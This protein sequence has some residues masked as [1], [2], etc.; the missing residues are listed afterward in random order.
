MD[1]EETGHI[2]FKVFQDSGIQFFLGSGVVRPKSSM[3][4]G[5]VYANFWTILM[6]VKQLSSTHILMAY[7]T[8][9]W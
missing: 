1:L 4:S 9:L 8:H 2:P 3:I 7:T 5:A 6:L